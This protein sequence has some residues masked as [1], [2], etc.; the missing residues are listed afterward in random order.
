MANIE[1]AMAVNKL[2]ESSK[3][4]LLAHLSEDNNLKKLA[5]H[6]TN[7]VLKRLGATKRDISLDIL[8]QYIP[9][10]IYDI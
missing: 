9:S 5:F 4:F 10:N 8:D 1:T 3:R 2:A 6:E 7:N